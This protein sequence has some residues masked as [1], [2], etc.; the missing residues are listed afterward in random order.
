MKLSTINKGWLLFAIIL[1]VNILQ[2]LLSPLLNDEAYY[3]LYAQH[4]AW[5]YLDHPPMVSFLI[6]IGS[7]IFPGE[8]GVR[9]IG[10]LFGS[11]TFFLIYKIIEEESDGPVNFKL[12]GLLL[13]SSLFLNL[14]SFLAIP[15]TPMLF[16]AVLFL[17]GYRKYLVN[18]S[19]LNAFILGVI[20]ALLFYSKYH[21]VLLI[22]F[23][24]LSNPKIFLRKTFYVVFIL[25]LVLYAP[26]LYWQYQNDFPTIRFQFFQRAGQFKIDHVFSY[27]GEQAAVTGPLVLLVFSLLYKPGNQF[28]KTLKYIVG[29]VFGFFFISSF[30]EMVNMHWT[31]IAFPAMLCLAYLYISKLK[32]RRKLITGILI[33]NLVIVLIFRTDFIAGFLPISNFNDKNPAVMTSLLKA[34]AKGLPLVFVDMYNEPSQYMFYGHDDCFAVNDVS[35][36]KTQFNY[37]SALE[38]KFQGKTIGL[39]TMGP[40]GKSSEEVIVPKGK[41]YYITEVPNFTSVSSGVSVSA[42]NFTKLQAS[43]QSNIKVTLKNTL[44]DEELARI[45]SYDPYLL[46]TF[47]NIKT[48]QNISY[49][50][51]HPPLERGN[52]AFYFPV[53]VPK[54]P[55]AYNCIFSFLTKGAVVV[56]FNSNIYNCK[57]E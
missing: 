2:S 53:K 18:D 39:V 28:Q 45:K 27:L 30:K 19:F 31:A 17:Y 44:N 52:N 8:I 16:F 14:Y 10:A 35:Y 4:P 46:L 40:F 22:V 36:K 9:L 33:F 29:G 15:D 41:K 5:G 38:D 51:D 37:L 56:G 1:A 13:C 47:I 42:E 11:L 21:G 54:E 25:A 43:A 49:K 55:G 23:T 34:K 12:A 7:S 6:N 26:H 20:V 32:T 50:L 24:I 3:W 48:N 57:V